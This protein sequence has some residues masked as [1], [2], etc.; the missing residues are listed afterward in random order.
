[1]RRILSAFGLL[2]SVA[3]SPAIAQN[4]L[5][6][7]L[8]E[9]YSGK[10]SVSGS[11]LVGAAFGALDGKADPRKLTVQLEPAAGA[12]TLCFSA[13]TR[14]GQYAAHAKVLAP[15]GEVKG[16]KIVP[17]KGWNYLSEL[18]AYNGT[19]F[20]T[21]I[22]LGKDCQIDPDTTILPLFSGSGERDV[23]TIFLNSQRAFR[24]TA[25]LDVPDS[26][27]IEG[28]CKKSSTM[29]IRST[30]FNYTCQFDL[31]GGDLNGKTSLSVSRWL[32]VGRR[33]DTFGVYLPA[34]STSAE[35]EK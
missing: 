15:A 27:P 33:S 23:L 6:I 17:S 12:S 8:N 13:T 22:R 18:R 25:R 16:A 4:D 34:V 1:M 21:I 32:S 31:K 9:D 11:V 7:D 30:A 28:V 2:V 26:A 29:E 14:D 5:L 20:A 35:A 19:D 24:V 10:V 3:I